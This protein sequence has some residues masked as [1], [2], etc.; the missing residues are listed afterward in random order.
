M[1][2]DL[3]PVCSAPMSVEPLPPKRSRTFSPGR[4]EYCIARTASSTG[5]SVR[6]IMLCGLTFFTDQTSVAFVGPNQ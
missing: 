5:F 3:R 6:W 4:E 1:R 2:N